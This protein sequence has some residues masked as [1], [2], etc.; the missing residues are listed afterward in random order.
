MVN[1]NTLPWV[2]DNNE[3]NIWDSLCIDNRDLLFMNTDGEIIYSINL[4]DEFNGQQIINNI[5]NLLD[6]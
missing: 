2:K 3:Y 6:N 1:G 4:T 5:N